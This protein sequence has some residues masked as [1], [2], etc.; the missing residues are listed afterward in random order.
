MKHTRYNVFTDTDLTGLM[1]QVNRMIDDGWQVDDPVVT[2]LTPNGSIL[3]IQ[4]M[5]KPVKIVDTRLLSATLTEINDV[6]NDIDIH[7]LIINEGW[8]LSSDPVITPHTKNILYTFFL[9]KYE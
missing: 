5:I 2:A 3:Y 1:V 6:W 7:H 4:K 9:V 8:E